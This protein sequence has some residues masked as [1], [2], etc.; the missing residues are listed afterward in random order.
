[1]I[2]LD[3]IFAFILSLGFAFIVTSKFIGMPLLD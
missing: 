1:M 3:D 2:S